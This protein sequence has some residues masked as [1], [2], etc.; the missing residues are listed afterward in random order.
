MS[1]KEAEGIEVAQEAAEVHGGLVDVVVVAAARWFQRR[2]Q[3]DVLRMLREE[4]L[5]V[6]QTT[7]G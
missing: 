4:C 7:I 6:T 2:V 1:N 3:I 5:Q